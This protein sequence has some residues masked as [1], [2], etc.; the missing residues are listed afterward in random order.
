M[1]KIFYFI[2]AILVIGSPVYAVSSLQL[3][4]N[5]ANYDWNTQTWVTTG[6]EFD[7][8]VV[9]ANSTKSDVI[10]GMSLAQGD[11]AANVNLNAGG[12]QY[13]SSDWVWGYAPIENKLAQWNGG[14]DLSRHGIFPTWY[15]E[16]NTGTYEIKTKVG[17]I[18]PDKFGCY[19]NPAN[20]TGPVSAVGNAKVFHIITGGTYSL[21]HFDAYTLNRDGSINQFAPS[22]HDAESVVPVPEPGT[23]AMLGMGLL[24]LGGTIRRRFKSK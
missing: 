18:Q 14:E 21:I 19:W 9:S 10:V 1:R 6:S 23:L 7:L 12:R 17:D 16:L 2:I 13:N 11:N 20:G 8:Y 3:F 24:G 22:S 15:T 4:I 5:G